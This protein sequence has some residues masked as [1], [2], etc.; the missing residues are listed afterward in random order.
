MAITLSLDRPDAWLQRSSLDEVSF[1][2]F[3]YGDTI[4]RCPEHLGQGY[5]QRITVRDGLKILILD[6]EFYDDFVRQVQNF[7]VPTKLEMTFVLKGPQAGR[8]RLFLASGQKVSNSIFQYPGGQ[9]ILKV[10]LHLEL[11]I[12]KIFLDSLLEKLPVTLRQS[13]EECF[14]AIYIFKTPSISPSIEQ[15]YSLINEGAVTPQ[16]HLVL[17]QILNCPFEGFS[18]YLYLEGKALELMT[19]RSQQIV[20]QLVIFAPQLAG[21]STLHPDEL[22]RIYQAKELLLSNLQNPP[23]VDELA[24]QVNLNRRKLNE[25]FQQV[26]H[27]TPFEYLQDYRLK[28][29][30]SILNHPDIKVEDVIQ[31]VGYKSR[32][33]FAVAFRK[34][35][36][37]NPKHYQQQQLTNV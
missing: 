26:F 35:F 17:R 25:I 1:D 20:E 29:A 7:E 8:S 4:L 2:Y 13:A 33:N 21:Q 31:I 22:Q 6:Y 30:Q 37:V 9:Q 27:M 36:G 15:V 34:K 11:P 28:Q 18:R 5:C 10:E 23:S 24:R 16:M 32:S 19:L 12:L 3:D 14:N